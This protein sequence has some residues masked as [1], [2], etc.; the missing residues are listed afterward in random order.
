M[1]L[2]RRKRKRGVSTTDFVF[3]DLCDSLVL[4]RRWR[5]FSSSGYYYFTEL[6]I[7]PAVV[8]YIYTLTSKD[9]HTLTLILYSVGLH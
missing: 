5:Y 3:L 4:M 1:T 9:F 6:I 2:A 8:E 7:S